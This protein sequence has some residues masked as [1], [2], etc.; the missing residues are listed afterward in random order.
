M[1]K[2]FTHHG[3]VLSLCFAVLVIVLLYLGYWIMNVP[4]GTITI[5][6]FLRILTRRSHLL[7]AMMIG[8]VLITL[9]S[10]VFQTMTQNRILTPSLMGFDAVYSAT[11]ILLVFTLGLIHPLFTDDTLN[12]VLSTLL[13]VSVSVAMYA[14][15]MKR[16]RTEFGLLLLL[17]LVI[18]S[19]LRSTTSFLATLLDPDEFQSVMATT[20]VSITNIAVHLLWVSLPLMVLLIVLFARQHK[21]LDVMSLGRAHSIGLGVH[22]D[23]VVRWNLLYISLAMAIATALIGPIAFLGLIAVNA[24]RE[25]VKSHRHAPLMVISSLLSITFLVGGQLI[26]E[27][28][29]FIT[30]V[31]VLINLVGG[32]YVVYLVL[33][34]NRV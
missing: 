3:L 23:H 28:T 8:A 26:V 29:G 2:W 24:A 32:L 10:V 16:H 14:T 9:A 17:G 15:L 33:K 11:Q 34:E 19:M 18:S 30:T 12:F 27:W 1:R 7:V 22:Y 6:V 13:M 31:T 25:L 21:T 4:S 20:S 5:E